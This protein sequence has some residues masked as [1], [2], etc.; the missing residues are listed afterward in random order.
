MRE[1]RVATFGELHERLFD[2]C[3]DPSL[4]RFRSRFAFRGV[5]AS[6]RDD[7]LVSALERLGP[8]QPELEGPMLRTFRKYARNMATVDDSVWSWLAVAQHHGFPTRQLDWTFSPYVALHF[9]TAELR[10]YE[11]DGVVWA[12]DYVRA[13]E[14]LPAPLARVLDEEAANVFTTDMLERAASSLRAFDALG[15]DFVAFLEPPALDERIVNQH[16]L[17]SVAPRGLRY[18]AW[19]R[20][21]PHLARRIVVPA[22]LK[23]EVRDKL[24]QANVTER[25]LFPGLD[26]LSRWLGRYYMPRP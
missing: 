13:K 19:L 25:V 10:D 24:D 21:H 20:Q 23:W 14:L 1:L 18:E 4:R 15:D 11:E 5:G 16:A 22:A 26:G 17:F 6:K 12:V 9:M 2:E 7:T 8:R 3:W